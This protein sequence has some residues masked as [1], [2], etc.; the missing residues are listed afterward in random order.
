MEKWKKKVGFLPDTE[1]YKPDVKETVYLDDGVIKRTI[2]DGTFTPP[3][4]APTIVFVPSEF[5]DEIP[6]MSQKEENPQQIEN[7]S[8]KYLRAAFITK[9]IQGDDDAIF[10][11]DGEEYQADGK[12]SI[13]IINDILSDFSEDLQEFLTPYIGT[14]QIEYSDAELDDWLESG[15]HT[16]LV[17][18]NNEFSET[19]EFVVETQEQEETPEEQE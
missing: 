17:S 1:G 8:G 9:V 11:I 6:G 7:G 10:T 14:H 2:H 4:Q 3:P 18:C 13:L 5:C 16:L 19:I 15:T 12:G